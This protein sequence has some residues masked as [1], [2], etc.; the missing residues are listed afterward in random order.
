M[1]RLHHGGARTS[2]DIIRDASSEWAIWLMLRRFFEEAEEDN[3]VP[4][5]LDIGFCLAVDEASI[6]SALKPTD[7]EDAWVWAVDTEF[8]F[9]ATLAEGAY[10]GYFKVAVSSL[11]TDFYPVAAAG[12]KTGAELWE[13][14]KP[15]WKAVL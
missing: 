12:E 10:P 9:D 1:L 2:C 3:M 11:I 13:M 15:V 8:D 6:D 4:P 7:G 5:G 14:A